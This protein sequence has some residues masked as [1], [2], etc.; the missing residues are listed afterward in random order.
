MLTEGIV[1]TEGERRAE[2]A[3][4][5]KGFDEAS[6]AFEEQDEQETNGWSLLR[7]NKNNIRMRRPKS[8]QTVLE[9]RLWN[10]LYRFGYQELNSQKPLEVELTVDGRLQ[11]TT[12]SVFAKDAETAVVGICKSEPETKALSMRRQ[13]ERLSSVQR[14]LANAIRKHYGHGFK[15][16]LLWVIA[17]DKIRW[18]SNDLSLASEHNIQVI[19]S[20][21]LLYFEEISK[22]LGKAARYQFHAEYLAD[23]KVPALT[24]RKVPAV[25]TKIGGKRAYFFSARPVDILR[26][27]FVN[28]RDLRDPTGAPSYQRLVKPNRLREIGSFLNEGGFF[29]NTI[30]LNFHRSPKFE[31]HTKDK[32]SG[33]QFGELILPDRYKSCWVIDGQHRLY[34]TTFANDTTIENPLFFIAFDGIKTDEEADI[35]V[36]INAK[37]TK[38]PPKLLAELDGEVKWNSSNIRDRLSAISSRAV[39]LLNNEGAG[40]LEGRVATPGLSNSDEQPLTLPIFQQ[41]IL[42]SKLLGSINS[43]TKDFIPGVCWDGDSER[44][45]IRM[46]EFLGWYFKHLEMINS[47]RWNSGK[48][49]YLCS[50][51]G[52]AGHIRLLGEIINFI[53]TKEN[54]NLSEAKLS[55]IQ[56]IVQEYLEPVFTFIKEADD[57]TFEKRFKVPFGSGGPAR[58]FFALVSL[59]RDQNRDFEPD[60]FEEFIQTISQE[61]AEQAD[62]DVKWIQTVVADYVISLLRQLYDDHF[63]DKGVP[64]EIQKACQTKRVDDDV[65][66]KLPVETYLDWIHLKKIIEQKAVRDV[67]G[68]TLS[69]QLPEEKNGRHSYFGWFDKL[70]EVRRIPAHPAGRYYKQEDID[71]LNTVTAALKDSLPKEIVEAAHATIS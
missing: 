52:V 5:R 17:T 44:S 18:S 56:S 47:H 62:K 41:A 50:N 34:G 36:T 58:Y 66:V 69:I 21:E 30:L 20:K 13:I 1:K 54:C 61:A 49:G 42:Q 67:A 14:P 38:V 23:Q 26:I 48:S 6:F 59:I 64:R 53:E 57:A 35:F 37:Q 3:K 68:S 55:E 40:A 25:R 29:P 2:Y 65:D 22:K 46:V 16:K 70:N 32:Q 33:I 71:L 31:R 45:L 39:D 15:P 7:Q 12:I 60:G 19:Q 43:R 24:G 27:A 9:N 63:F 11:R 28:H 10:V 51:F 8:A 4:R